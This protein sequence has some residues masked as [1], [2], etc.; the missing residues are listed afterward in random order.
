MT[1]S[2]PAAGEAGGAADRPLPFYAAQG[3]GIARM[4]RPF[5]QRPR[6]VLA[7]QRHGDDR[8][9]RHRWCRARQRPRQRPR[10]PEGLPQPDVSETRPGRRHHLARE[11]AWGWASAPELPRARPGCKWARPR[12]ARPMPQRVAS[13]SARTSRTSPTGSASPSARPAPQRHRARE[14]PYRAMT[15]DLMLPDRCGISL[16]RDIR[17][18]PTLAYLPRV[19]ECRAKSSARSRR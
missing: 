2:R 9:F 8:L 18:D 1:M 16:V 6:Q 17:A 5:R 3:T 13:S 4:I 15:L 12:K 19:V 7:P 14:R 11:G 10:H